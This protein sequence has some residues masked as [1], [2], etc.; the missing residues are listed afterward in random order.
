MNNL[1]L[2]I[3]LLFCCGILKA[4]GDTTK[5]EIEKTYRTVYKMNGKYLRPKKILA[6]TESSPDAYHEMRIAKR[7]GDAGNVIIFVGGGLLA[8]GLIRPAISNKEISPE[9]IGSGSILIL[10]SLPINATFLNRTKKAVEIYNNDLS[11]TSEIKYDLKLSYYG[12]G[13]GLRLNF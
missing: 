9:F 1:T 13:L 10:L 3:L 2:I 12:N 7:H 6:I 5:I 11:A 4:Q 8:Y